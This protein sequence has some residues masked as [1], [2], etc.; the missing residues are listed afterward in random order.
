MVRPARLCCGDDHCRSARGSSLREGADRGRDRDWDEDPDQ[1]RGGSCD[2]DG[3]DR[4][5]PG[6]L[7]MMI[8]IPSGTQVWLATGHTNMRKGFDRL[9]LLVQE[10]MKRD[11]RMAAICS[12][13]AAAAAG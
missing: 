1:R 4:G 13:S 8:P 6:G 5:P 12:C 2:G 3:G 7:A 9:S 10:T 11:L